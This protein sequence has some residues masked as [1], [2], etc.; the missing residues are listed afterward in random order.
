MTLD[1][2][3]AGIVIAYVM[4]IIGIAGLF[5]EIFSWWSGDC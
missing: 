2:A 1:Q 3:A 4:I 5:Y